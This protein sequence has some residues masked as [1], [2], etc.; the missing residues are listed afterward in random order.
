MEM[1]KEKNQAFWLKVGS[2]LNLR[3]VGFTY[4]QTALFDYIIDGTSSFKTIVL[5]HE[6]ALRLISL[7]NDLDYFKKQSFYNRTGYVD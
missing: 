4:D 6:L 7:K 5:D 1:D 2:V 3:L